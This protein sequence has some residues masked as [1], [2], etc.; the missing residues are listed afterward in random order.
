MPEDYYASRAVGT[1]SSFKGFLLAG[2]LSFAGGAALIG[3]LVWNGQIDVGREVSA[4]L[5][6]PLPTPSPSASPLTSAALDQQIAAMEQRLARLGLQA[7]AF[8]GT[9]VR[10]EGLLVAFATRRAVEQGQ[11]LGYLEGQLQT[12]FGSAR[13]DAVKLVTAAAKTPLTL[14]MLAAQLDDLGP[15]LLGT[16]RD[17]SA[18]QS[19]TRT[20]GGL[21]VIKRDDGS[22]RP[23]QG[24]LDQARLMLRSGRVNE[25][26]A[27]ITQMPGNAAAVEWITAARRYAA[28]QEALDQI[29]QAAL[30]EPQLLKSGEGETV[31]QPGLN[32]PPVPTG[33]PVT[34]P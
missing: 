28:T 24:R 20:M 18:W 7:A 31:N 6:A 32:A 12:R 23:A 16:R 13:P 9:S 11:P 2:L 17:E 15:A 19:F 14:D 8:D 21:F 30:T 34:K 29:E 25:A 33:I 1:G 26:I 22:A 10:A 5:A 3:Y 4:P 27:E